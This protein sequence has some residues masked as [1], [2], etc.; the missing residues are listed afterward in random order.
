M[1]RLNLKLVLN[2]LNKDILLDIL[3]NS[4]ISPLKSF[5]QIG[6]LYDVDIDYTE[7][8]VNQ[9]VYLALKNDTGARGLLT[10]MN[11]VKSKLLIPI[12]TGEIESITLTEDVLSDDFSIELK[13]PRI[14]SFN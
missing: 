12:M 7:E 3:L 5:I 14:L 2:D 11:E 6:K 4:N 8:F 13:R 10:I 9:V 1:G